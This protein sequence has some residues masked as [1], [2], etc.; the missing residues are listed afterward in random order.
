[1]KRTRVESMKEIKTANVDFPQRYGADLKDG[2]MLSI[3]TGSHFNSAELGTLE[4]ALL[5]N[6][7]FAFGGENSDKSI[8]HYI[9][10][11]KADEMLAEMKQASSDSYKDIFKKY[12]EE[13]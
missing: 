13:S 9:E 6:N 12:R 11:D 2:Y 5:E 7:Y 10:P 8:I 4:I 3:L 1:M